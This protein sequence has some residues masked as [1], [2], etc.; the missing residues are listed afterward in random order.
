MLIF[1]VIIMHEYQTSTI[2]KNYCRVNLILVFFCFVLINW[3]TYI[4]MYV[5]CAHELFCTIVSP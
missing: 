1:V 2:I 5:Q 3:I 4:H